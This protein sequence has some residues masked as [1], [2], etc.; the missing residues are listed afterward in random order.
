MGHIIHILLC[1]EMI[2]PVRN[3]RILPCNFSINPLKN[4]RILKKKQIKNLCGNK[5]AFHQRLKIDE[6][7]GNVLIYHL[8]KHQ[9]LVLSFVKILSHM[10]NVH[11][12]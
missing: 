4:H 11:L 1:E 5:T 7:Y 3:K 2:F 9:N 6:S 8:C 12:H 10:L